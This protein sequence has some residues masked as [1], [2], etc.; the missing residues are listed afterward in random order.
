MNT[1]SPMINKNGRID[2]GTHPALREIPS[3]SLEEMDTIKLMNRID[4]KYVTNE[5]LLVEILTEAKNKGYRALEIAET[6]LCPYISTYYDTDNLA[7]YRDHHNKKLVRQ[8][9]RTR[10]YEN[11][12]TAF[13]EIKKKNN[14]GRT[15]K[16]RVE[17][18][19][20]AFSDFRGDEQR[21]NFVTQN[22]GY[23]PQDI[24]PCLQTIFSRI[25][26][27]NAAKTERLTID[28][29][30]RFVN[31]LNNVEKNL[32]NAVVIELKQDGRAKSEMKNILLDLRVKPLRMSKYCIGTALTNP[33]APNHRFKLKIRKIEKIINQKL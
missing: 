8:K 24:Q 17:I 22:T 2:F 25:T 15:K 20:A 7:M 28:T 21:N 19:T 5:N 4:T 11:S 23:Q 27:V 3:I 33:S 30:L 12:N 16:K 14:K 10:M 32:G 6:K 29:A 31:V 26:L 13:L 18:D 9:I 1:L